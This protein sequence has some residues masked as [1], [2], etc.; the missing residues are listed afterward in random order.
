MFSLQ[1]RS[2][3]QKIKFAILSICLTTLLLACSGILI[4]EFITFRQRMV[5][6]LETTAQ[7][8]GSNSTGAL[9]FDNKKDAEDVLNALRSQPRIIS[10]A[11]YNQK[12]YL[13]ASYVRDS[14]ASTPPLTIFQTGSWFEKNRL[15]LFQPILLNKE[16]VG[17]IFLES[18][19]QTMYQRFTSYVSIVLLVL[20][21]AT[22]IAVSAASKFQK[23]ISQPI[24]SLA[25]TTKAIS[26]QSDYSIRAV[27]TS[28]D[29]IGFLADAINQMLTQIQER[30]TTLQQANETM[31]IEIR[32][33]K[34]AEEV[35]RL[36]EERFR[37]LFE[38]HPLPMWV[39]DLA[40]LQFLEVNESA[41]RQ[42]GYS[43]DEFLDMRI[44][45]I[46]PPEEIPRLVENLKKQRTQ[47]EA[48][49]IWKHRLKDGRI[50]D[51]EIVSHQT[52]YFN[53]QAILVVAIDVTERKK[54]EQ[55]LK[56]S[57]ERYRT[58]VSA[59]TSIVW[60]VD[61]EGN[62]TVPQKS[63]AKYTGQQWEEHAG[64]GWLNAFHPDDRGTIQQQWEQAKSE[65]TLYESEGRIWNIANQ[66]YRYFVA[67]AVPLSD[68]DGTVREWIG[69]VTDVHDRKLAEQEI[70]KL[71]EELEQRVIERTVQLEAVNKELEA[72]S[73]SV[74]HDLR[75]PLRS[76]DG[77]SHA[78]LEDYGTM[79]D[80]KG[81]DYLQRV[82]SASQR[83]AQLIDDLLNLSRLTRAEMRRE[84]VNLSEMVERI[85][86]EL[87]KS[88]PERHVEFRIA[89]NVL[90][91][92]D[93]RLL[94]IV[95]D[96]LIGNAW[97]YTAK[98][99]QASIE[100][101]IEQKNGQQAYYVRDDG[102]GFDMAYADKLFGA[103]QRLHA[104]SDF[105]GTGIGLVT[106]QRIVRRHGGEIWAESKVEQGATFYF[107]LS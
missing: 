16:K 70:L 87:Q 65:K 47:L 80:D 62:F 3:Q 85:T 29:E 81:K 17:T 67:R 20:I 84:K 52:L 90:A 78:F 18:D 54:A 61:L 5:N 91:E 35:L 57:E 64:R 1:R 38:T 76:I 106:A 104:V 42:Y 99:E 2:I 45:E 37:H 22:G 24:L 73:Y 55:D 19:L 7:I 58:L 33:R 27:K 72:F 12:N 44:S 88:Q 69:T 92:G 8:I 75:A 79:V 97:K 46:R 39:Y 48:S 13:F 40:T 28:D 100:F 60:T 74:S 82:R 66:A 36:S 63:W 105:P 25:Q 10:A 4:Y 68:S 34:R 77:F 43:R 14:L 101:N 21:G 11:V 56:K 94:R 51:V 96:N 49:G 23:K 71:N 15:V 32:E 26:Q 103:F 102:A 30:D 9:A 93:P 89:E 86:D 50:V 98:H 41:I 31:T 6:G 107:T 95:L 53:R 59:M 83:M